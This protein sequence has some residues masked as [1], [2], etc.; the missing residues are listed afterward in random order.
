MVGRTASGIGRR[1]VAAL[2]V[3]A[4][5]CGDSGRAPESRTQGRITVG[6]EPAVYELVA[7]SARDF[8]G[9][10]PRAEVA[11]QRQGSREA[12]GDLFLARVEAAVVGREALPE[13]REAAEAGGIGIEALRWARDAV[14]IVVHPDNPVE[15]V[16]FEDL[17]EIY[18][19]KMVSWSAL[20]GSDERI[21]PIVQDP[22]RSITQFFADRILEGEPI[23]GPARVANGDSTAAAWAAGERNAVAFVALPYAARGVR[24]LRVSRLKGL[25]YV[26]LDARS[27]YEDR[28]PLTRFYNVF[29]RQPGSPLAS[30]FTTFLCSSDGQRRVRDAGLVPATVPVRF[31]HRAPTLSARRPAAEETRDDDE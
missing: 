8:Q 16:A 18:T 5:A 6:V 1:G 24:P 4:A 29:L 28:Y 23:S 7:A 10:Y 20:G 14:A 22:A 17:R 13:E 12:V 19:G 21:I 26:E 31:T 15:Q 9:L 2:L 11:V 27:V 25:A 30:G 3:A